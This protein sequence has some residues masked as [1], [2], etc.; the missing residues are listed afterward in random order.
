MAVLNAFYPE[1]DG[2]DLHL[3]PDMVGPRLDQRLFLEFTG[4]VNVR[5]DDPN[6]VGANVTFGAVLDGPPTSH[7]ID[8]RVSTGEIRMTTAAPAAGLRSFIVT[9]TVVDDADPSKPRT[10]RLRVHVHSAIDQLWL[11]PN[12]LTVRLGAKGIH[13]TLLAKFTDGVIA[14][15]SNWGAR[16][17]AGASPTPFARVKGPVDPWATVT[18]WLT[19]RNAPGSTVRVDPRTGVL[20]AG[21]GAEPGGG[22]IV[23]AADVGPGPF[24]APA[25]HAEA[26]IERGPTW[27]TRVDL[28][29][30]GATA[31]DAFAHVTERTNVLI[32]PDGFDSGEQGAFELVAADLVG[33]LENEDRT[34]PFDLFRG[35]V[36]YFVA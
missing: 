36:N 27:D 30:I 24:V 25:S 13:L 29:P 16:E 5:A 14:D 4:G 7:G 31:G 8:L 28:K 18:P 34:R 10:V 15:V 21:T 1:L 22:P 32:L 11:A 20:T 35:Q 17:I 26:N 9:A 6:I 19:W 2:D 12:P 33:K 3:V 23:I